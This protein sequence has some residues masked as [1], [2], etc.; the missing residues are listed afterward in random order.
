[1]IEIR[2]SRQKIPC[3]PEAQLLLE[4]FLSKSRKTGRVIT[5]DNKK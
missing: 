4:R 2:N 5:Y 3:L 1:M